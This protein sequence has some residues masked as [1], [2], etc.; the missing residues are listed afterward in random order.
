MTRAVKPTSEKAHDPYGIGPVGSLI[1]PI[2]SVVGLILIAVVTINLFDYNLPLLG[3]GGGGNGGN[4][5]VAGPELTPAP[6]NVIVVPQEARFLGKIVYAKAGNIWVQ[7]D[8]GAT[9]LTNGG[10]ASM[11]S[12]SPDGNWVYYI[13]DTPTRG[14]WPHRGTPTWYDIDLNELFRIRADGSGQPQRLL[15]GQVRSGSNR[16]SAWI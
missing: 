16:W 9:Q 5:A 10:G 12:F 6:S 3:G 2:V 4:G 13:H 11:P 7:S 8:E 15:S 14:K 1:G